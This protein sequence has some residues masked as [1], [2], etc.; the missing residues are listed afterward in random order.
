MLMSQLFSHILKCISK[1]FVAF[2]NRFFKSVSNFI[3]S[4]NQTPKSNS[5]SGIKSV[6]VL[7]KMEWKWCLYW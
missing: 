6:A 4:E 5:S 2:F 1:Y 3:L 7:L